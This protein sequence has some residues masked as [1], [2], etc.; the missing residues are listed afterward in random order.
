MRDSFLTERAIIPKMRE[1]R[2]AHRIA[3]WLCDSKNALRLA[4]SMASTLSGIM[5]ALDD[6][7]LSQF[8]RTQA[9]SVA[10]KVPVAPVAAS[11]LEALMEEG[12]GAGDHQRPS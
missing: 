9:S 3:L 5:K 6:A 8:L 11:V 1:W 4:T 10:R 2:M 7:K 12:Q